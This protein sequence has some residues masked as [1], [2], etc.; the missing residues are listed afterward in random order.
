MYFVGYDKVIDK[1]WVRWLFYLKVIIIWF[2]KYL[3]RNECCNGMYMYDI[4][5]FVKEDVID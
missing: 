4:I 5:Y 1:V 3:Y 2:V